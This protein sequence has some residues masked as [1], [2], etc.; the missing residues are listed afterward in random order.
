M[1]IFRLIRFI[2]LNDN[3][4]DAIS[5]IYWNVF[6]LTIKIP[7]SKLRNLILSLNFLFLTIIDHE[8]E[9]LK[10]FMNMKLRLPFIDIGSCYGKYAKIML[11]RCPKV[12]A[13]E[14][15]PFNM[16]LLKK[17]I[18]LRSNIECL[19]VAIGK[20]AGIAKFYRYKAIGFSSMKPFKSEF[21]DSFNVRMVPLN[22]IVNEN[23]GLIK[24][25]VEGSEFDV[26]NGANEVITYIKRWLIEVHLA[27][28][29]EL[30]RR[31]EEL[32]YT[33]FWIDESHIY[34]QLR[35]Q[36]KLQSGKRWLV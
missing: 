3:L 33:T 28:H 8:P 35:N 13:V 14:P 32:G 11:D 15:D 30:E 34:A 4:H 23:I 1:V 22:D 10:L 6:N 21:I 26:L 18:G 17:N 12:I 9:V 29:D 7:S 36:H 16:F 31:L 5:K 27:K 19:Q 24:V 2:I 20:E 25:D